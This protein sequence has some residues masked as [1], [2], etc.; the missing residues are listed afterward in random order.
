MTHG[1]PSSAPRPVNSVARALQLID[2]LAHADGGLGV[3]ELSRRIGVNPSTASRLLA[4]LEAGRIVERENGGPYQLGIGLL[5]LADKVLA[6]LDVRALA[7]PWL[8]QLVAETGETATLSLPGE[9]AAITV[10][11]V[12]SAS[13]IMSVARLWQPSVAHATA[14][15]KV[16]LA[17]GP[18]ADPAA[19]L[20]ELPACTD[21]TI[22]DRL[23]L[24]KELALTRERGFAEAYREREPD[25]AALAVPVCGRDGALVAILGLQ[26]PASRLPAAK[27]RQLQPRL[28][29]AAVEIERALGAS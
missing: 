29:H 18:A 24:A 14:V 8:E 11:F 2:L 16:M 10:D 20:G 17:F 7:R 9:Q 15:G 12:L 19:Q 5:T 22:T 6:R 23:K 4:T 25:L 1:S 27:R 21:R 28:R 13:S 26:G 3:N